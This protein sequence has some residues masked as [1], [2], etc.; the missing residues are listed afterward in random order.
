[1]SH[2]S[3][4]TQLWDQGVEIAAQIIANL[5]S[6]V[7]LAVF[8]G[9][10]L[11]KWNK[12]REHKEDAVHRAQS[13]VGQLST[14]LEGFA[15]QAERATGQSEASRTAK[16]WRQWMERENLLSIGNNGRLSGNWEQSDARFSSENARV[17]FKPL[18]AELATDIRA[19]EL[20]P[21]GT[22]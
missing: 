6:G 9:L 18:L 13:R 10:I 19:T 21:A 4:V 15:R 8:G 12:R 16:S 17:N 7:I 22:P 11:W 5:I 3:F 20:P 2:P 1:M 14:E